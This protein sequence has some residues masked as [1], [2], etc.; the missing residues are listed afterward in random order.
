MSQGCGADTLQSFPSSL[1]CLGRPR[2]CQS[3]AWFCIYS[4]LKLSEKLPP[5]GLLFRCKTPVQLFQKGD[6]RSMPRHSADWSPRAS[7]AASPYPGASVP[8][9]SSK[10]AHPGLGSLACVLSQGAGQNPLSWRP[11]QRARS[12]CADL[13]SKAFERSRSLQES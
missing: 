8:R 10:P 11:L 4:A 9:P 7:C 1:W 12:L 3:P 6:P 13:R 2:K 5:W